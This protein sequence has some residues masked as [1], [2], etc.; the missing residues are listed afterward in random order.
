M[1][2]F[3]ALKKLCAVKSY[4]FY[5]QNELSTCGKFVLLI[6]VIAFHSAGNAIGIM[7]SFTVSSDVEKTTCFIGW[8]IDVFQK[9]AS[10]RSWNSENTGLTSSKC[11]IHKNARRG[12]ISKVRKPSEFEQ[13]TSV[14]RRSHRNRSR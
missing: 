1:N 7:N 14:Y 5:K 11:G 13:I 12:K 4:D 6:K 8:S 9:V 3:S 2:H 10:V